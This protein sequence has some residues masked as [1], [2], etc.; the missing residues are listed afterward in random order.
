VVPDISEF[1]YGFALTR[2]LIALLPPLNVAPVFPSLIAE[3]KKGGGYDVNLDGL[4]FP[5]FIQFKRSEC[6]LRRSAH[7]TK[8][9]MNFSTPYY[10]MRITE[11][12]R[13]AQHEML[14][15][16]DAGPNEVFY[17][18]PLLHTVR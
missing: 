9:P 7:E 16:L 17:A 6:M 12:W 8:P 2:E 5:L 3:G 11:R 10:R 14:L 4:G 1:S 13:S 18:A 15:E